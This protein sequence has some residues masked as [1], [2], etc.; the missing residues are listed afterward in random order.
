MSIIITPNQLVARDNR[1]PAPATKPDGS[2]FQW[3]M[4]YQSNSMIADIDSTADA[5]EVLSPGYASLSVEEK[6][7][8]RIRLAQ[9]V[10]INARSIIASRISQRTANELKDWE[11]EVLL[12]QGDP[13]GWQ[14]GTGKLGEQD[15]EHVD[16][17]FSSI[18]LVLVSTSYAPHTEIVKP[19][20]IEGD[21]KEVK[22]L[23]WLRPEYELE[24]LQTLSRIG[25]ITFGRPAVEDVY[26]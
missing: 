12:Y 23:I 3:R 1:A 20:S 15:E 2:G 24:F 6:L 13:Y 22:N 17:W 14:D 10:Q 25:Y 9:T 26:A 4:F 8:D 19:V 21:Y 11:W 18:P 7:E 16:I 5:L